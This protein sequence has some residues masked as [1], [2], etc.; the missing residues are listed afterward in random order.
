M[1][2]GSAGSLTPLLL[3]YH[4]DSYSASDQGYLHGQQDAYTQI[5]LRLTWRSAGGQLRISGFV[6]N[7]SDEEVI[8]RANIY[9]AT[10]ATRQHGPPRTWGVS[11]GYHFQQ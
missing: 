4:S 2:L 8:T 3:L 5:D 1:D 9:G 6:N 11:F 7:L 10:V